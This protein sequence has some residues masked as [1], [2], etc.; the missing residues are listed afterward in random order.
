MTLR[1]FFALFLV[2]FVASAEE[3]FKDRIWLWCHVEGAHNDGSTRIYN[4]LAAKETTL[5]LAPKTANRYRFS[6]PFAVSPHEAAAELGIENVL[7]VKYNV[8]PNPGPRRGT[9][10]SYYESHGFDR[11]TRVIW[12]LVGEGGAT[13]PLEQKETLQLAADKTNICGFIMD[14]FF[15]RPHGKR[16]L[17]PGQIRSL[18]PRITRT[19]PAR[20]DRGLWVVL[21]DSDVHDP[22]FQ[23]KFAPWLK[24]V[25]GITLW[26]RGQAPLRRKTME[27]ALSRLEW[28]ISRFPRRPEIILGCYMWRYLERKHGQI[29]PERMATQLEFAREHLESGRL[30]GVIFLGSPIV[31]LSERAPAR[32]NVLAVK[33]WI[34]AYGDRVLPVR[35]DDNERKKSAR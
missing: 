11:F 32:A 12:S 27:S 33:E 7:M 29:E 35:P 4:D 30:S 28:K 25:D 20:T 13:S 14:D 19:L 23:A 17:T 15:V 5:G 10:R 31:D 2:P 26:F 34:A 6:Y 24:E 1:L 22:R 8:G 9:F 18:Q 21:Y 16:P 3:R